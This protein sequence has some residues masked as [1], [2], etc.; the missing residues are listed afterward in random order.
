MCREG[1]FKQLIGGSFKQLSDICTTAYV[2]G[3]ELWEEDFEYILRLVKEFIGENKKRLQ[4]RVASE[5]D[6][7]VAHNEVIH[8]K[9]DN[10]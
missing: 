9:G 1:K 7:A 3:N 2:T 6:I 5:Q 10:T 8:P 4:L